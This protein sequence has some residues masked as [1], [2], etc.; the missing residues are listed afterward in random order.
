MLFSYLEFSYTLMKI[1]FT[2]CVRFEAFPEQKEW[3]W[4]YDEDPD[5]LFLLGDNIYMDYGIWPFS[6]EYVG[7]PERLTNEG[8]KEVMEQKYINQFEKVP[9]F[10]RL[11]DKMRA[12]NGFFA[13]WDD[14]DFAWNNAYGTTVAPVKKQI[15]RELFHKYTQ[16]STNKPFVYYHVDTPMARV[17]FLDNRSDSE[18]PG[19]NSRLIS[20]A[21]FQFI[22]EKLDHKLPY[23]VLCGGIS[24]TVSSENWAKYPLELQRLCKLLTQKE[25]VLFLAGDIHYNTFVPAKYLKKLDCSTPPQF[26][27]S[28]MQINLLG[29]PLSI[30]NSHNWAKLC[31]EEDKAEITFYNRDKV[32]QKKSQKANQ[33]IREHLF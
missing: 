8:F 33:W 22:E 26:I 27:A 14:H 7:S 10:K 9:A 30:D 32:Q 2:S 3:D 24:L 29:L 23:T 20:D 1:I 15:S 5:Y 19:K 18:K 13:I 25:K 17:I 4:I 6:K 16:C 12:K 21:Q 28:G 11:L 31:L